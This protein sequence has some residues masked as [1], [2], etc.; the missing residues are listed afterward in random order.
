MKILV[1]DELDHRRLEGFAGPGLE[2]IDHPGLSG[3]ALR[4]EI[5]DCAGLVAGA[6]TAVDEELLAAA[7]LL[8]IIGRAGS[9]VDNVDVAAASRRGVLVMNTP[10]ANANAAAEHA[11]AM[12]CA[13]TRNLAPADAAMKEGRF[14][15]DAY[16][17]V[18]LRERLL[19]VLGLGHV[20]RLVAEK[21][22]GL[23][24]RV[25]GFDPALGLAARREM[26]FECVDLEDAL[27]FAD[28]VSLHVPLTPNT[29][30][31]VNA[32]LLA[33]MKPGVRIV[34]CSRGGVVDEAA[35]ADAL[36]EGHIA[37]AALDVFEHE[38]PFETPLIDAPNTLLTPHLGA[39]TA[40][41]KSLVTGRI[42]EQVRDY[43]VSG[44]VRGGV[45]GL[46]VD[47]KMKGD[48]E[49]FLGLARR[50]GRVT[51]AIHGGIGRVTARYYGEVPSAAPSALSACFLRGLLGAWLAEEVHEFAAL[52]VARE[53]GIE[54]EE[55]LREGHKSFRALL[56]FELE[57]EDGRR[58]TVAGTL[59][60]KEGFRLVRID[61]FN[62]DAIPEGTMLFV[63]NRDVPGIVGMIGSEL[64]RQG[65]NIANLSM[66]RDRKDGR[67]LAVF[68]LDDAPDSSF[69]EKL[70]A[71]PD[72][73]GV[74]LIEAE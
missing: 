51:A 54:V 50:L 15:P 46:A 72:F 53:R 63:S 23:G 57:G 45:N 39:A 20:G 26:N 13:L 24:M 3:E 40:E 14:E 42:L 22:Q 25:I 6:R 65:V 67:A 11:I 37:G 32:D 5:A 56:A 19:A 36:R 41:A 1:T 30:H 4:R 70:R 33:G 9:S 29:R 31:L 44:V 8:R 59:F 35:L 43:L 28:F 48:V 60:G 69:L 2:I 58:T 55:V 17:G 7:P 64:G 66:G 47:P 21:A 68:N 49:P 18:E 52:E 71:T 34:N 73:T 12:L 62:L 27:A 16:T 74:T 38:A 10:G 61:D